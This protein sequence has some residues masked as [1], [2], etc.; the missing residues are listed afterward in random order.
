MKSTTLLLLV[1]A[2]GVPLPSDARP[3]V[4]RCCLVIPVPDVPDRPTCVQLSVRNRRVTPRRACRLIGGRP[5]GRGDCTL[6]ACDPGA[7]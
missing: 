6:A 4:S 5:I 2:A 3:R 7:S 1:L